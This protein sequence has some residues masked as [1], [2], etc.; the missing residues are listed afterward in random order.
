[1]A[2]YSDSEVLLFEQTYTIS[3]QGTLGLFTLISYI[4]FYRSC[5]NFKMLPPPPQVGF[6]IFSP[7]CGGGGGGY[8]N[9]TIK[10]AIV[11][12]GKKDE[13]KKGNL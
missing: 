12:K 10:G 3:T 9:G 2:T 11:K 8:E 7:F 1:M 13:R 4:L 5:L 6:F